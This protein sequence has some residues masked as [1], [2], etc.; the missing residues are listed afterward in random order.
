MVMVSD[1]FML[2]SIV[3]MKLRDQY[4]TLEDLCAEEGYD[5]EELVGKLRDAGFEYVP[6]NNQFK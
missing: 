2:L 3:N 5:Q 1:P 4:D 6:E